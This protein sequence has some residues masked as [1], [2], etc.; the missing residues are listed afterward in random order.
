MTEGD[1]PDPNA[2][3][4]LGKCRITD[5][6]ENLPEEVARSKSPTL[7]TPRAGSVTASDK[8]GGKA[9]AIE[10]QRHGGLDEQQI[11]ALH[12]GQ[13]LPGGVDGSAWRQPAANFGCTRRPTAP[14]RV[15]CL[16][17]Q[18]L[19]VYRDWL[20][21][22]DAARPL[23]HYQLLRLKQFEDDS[24]KIR[25]HYRKMNAHVRKF[26]TGEFAAAIAGPAQR[27]GQGHALPDRLEPQAAITTP[28]LG[29]K[30]ERP[31]PPP[32]AGRDSA[33]RQGHRSGDQLDKARN[34]AKAIG[35]EV[36]DALM[37]QKLARAGRGDAAY[38]ESIGLP[39][40]DLT[41]FAVDPDLIAPGAGHRS[42]APIPACRCWSTRTSC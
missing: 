41:D 40:L 6:R 3:S 8:T 38:A 27:A 35:V 17:G 24:G 36:R 2:C 12:A 21:I 5:C 23:N 32:L 33:G 39:Y 9:A 4:L 37:Q 25:E 13:G 29:R 20:Q 26:A 30:D 16:H 7:S 15:F 1:A 11:D 42:P 34:F 10:I 31:G 28:A 18:E 19:D 14:H 22:N